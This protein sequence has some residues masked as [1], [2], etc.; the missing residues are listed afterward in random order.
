MKEELERQLAEYLRFAGLEATGL[1]VRTIAH[2]CANTAYDYADTLV[3]NAYLE[4]FEDAFE[5]AVTHMEAA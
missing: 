5:A 1:D 4:G 3:N 2:G